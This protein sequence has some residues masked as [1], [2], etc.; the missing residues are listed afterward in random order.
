[1]ASP[2]FRHSGAVAGIAS[3][4]GNC[5]END[6]LRDEREAYARKLLQSGIEVTGLRVLATHHDLA[7]LNALADTPATIRRPSSW[8]RRSWPKR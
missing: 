7:L 4:T 1:M 6:I 8:L 3:G 5:G 2:T